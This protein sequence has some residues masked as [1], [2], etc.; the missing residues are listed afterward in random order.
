MSISIPTSQGKDQDLLWGG[1][2]H[3]KVLKIFNLTLEFFLKSQFH[4]SHFSGYPENSSSLLGQ[5]WLAVR[6]ADVNPALN[7]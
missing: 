4:L 7:E 6:Y 1:G 5:G 2:W 3:P